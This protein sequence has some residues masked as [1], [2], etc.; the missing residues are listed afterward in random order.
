MC[1][2]PTAFQ[3]LVSFILQPYACV[4]ILL[5][6][7]PS[8]LSLL[9]MAAFGAYGSSQ[10]RGRIETTAASL[11]HS[12]SNVGFEPLLQAAMPDP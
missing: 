3:S 9:F 1:L 12:H 4:F 10:A 2:L 8:F 7:F 5:F 11:R 6:S